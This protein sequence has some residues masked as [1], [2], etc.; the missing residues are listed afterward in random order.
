MTSREPHDEQGDGPS[1]SVEDPRARVRSALPADLEPDVER[2]H[3]AILREPRDPEEGHE[4]APRWFWAGAVLAIFWGGWYLGRFGGSFGPATHV[5]LGARDPM[6]AGGA[7]VSGATPVA[8]PVSMGKQVFA[9]HCQACHQASGR[10]IP[11][12]FPPLVGSEWAVGPPEVLARILL[13]GLQGP[14]VVAG[15]TYNGAMP[16]WRDQL[17]DEEIAAVL[18]YLR[19]W[20]PNAAPPVATTLV[21]GVRNSTGARQAPWTA[22]ELRALPG[23]GKP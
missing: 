12:A 4:R 1:Q 18:T 15:E 5:A 21:T 7:A 9:T 20:A 13:N 10:G 16:A 19:Q 2:L 17:S 14:I 8:D 23:L 3:R 6:R 22:A 11:N